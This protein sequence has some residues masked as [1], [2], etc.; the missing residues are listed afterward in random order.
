MRRAAHLYLAQ[1]AHAW[2]VQS[3]HPAA[4]HRPSV[5]FELAARNADKPSLGREVRV[6]HARTGEHGLIPP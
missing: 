3:Q 6:T 1:Q 5:L 4:R 2:A